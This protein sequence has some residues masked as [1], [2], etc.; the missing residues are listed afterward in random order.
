MATELPVL[1]PVQLKRIEAVHRGFLYQHLYAVGC[2][3]L[4][5]GADASSVIVE[6]DEDIEIV[7]PDRRLYV[8]VKTRTGPLTEGDIEGAMKRFAL[9]RRE[10]ANGKRP[11]VAAFAIVANAQPG[12]KLADRLKGED[13]P[14]DT[15]LCWPA[16]APTDKALPAAW[17]DVAE[18]LAS[19]ADLAA[20]LPFGSL[21]PETLVWKL[22]GLVM[23]AASGTPPHADHAFRAEEL[24]DLFEQLAVQLQDFP[25]PP[26]RYRSQAE[27]PDLTSDA[28]V[29]VITGFSGAGKTMWV[30][31]AAQHSTAALAYSDV[32]DTPGPAIALPL[33]RELAGRFFGKGGGLGQLLLPGATGTEMLRAI[34]LRLQ[35]EKVDATIVIDNAHRV[36]AENLRALVQQ[37]P[38]AHFIFLAQPGAAVQELQATLALTPEPLGGWTTDTIAAEAA[39]QGCRADYAACERLRNLTA[40][41][42]LYVQNVVQFTAAE[43]A[44][45]LMRFCDE[46][47]ARTHDVATVQE[48]ILRRVFEGLG[49]QS[50][51]TVAILCLA[52][53][54][55]ERAEAAALLAQI[56]GLDNRAF[57]RAIRELR[58]AGVIELFGGDR[59]KI[60][61]AMRVLGRAHLD[62]LGPDFEHAAQSALKDVL[63]ASILRE[64]D[65]AKFS[66]YFRVL[67]DLGDIKMLV[68]LVTDEFI[69]RWA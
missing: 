9:L 59:L 18:G 63:L 6:A 68:E 5:S 49:P 32:G 11:G 50:R 55:L 19:C 33:A 29:R 34:G 24:P 30:A 22:A 64:K 36:P 25:A 15:T 61:D 8:Q 21:V 38:H 48:I 67:A 17:R 43:Y 37:T 45:E 44:G 3:L 62:S 28:R 41:L 31:Q 66:L 27:E 52:D 58:S 65:L 47:E 20:A 23:Y 14:T 35:A 16:N 42:P 26:L 10:H 51:D 2:L 53:I 39:D 46:L 57:A 7:L 13:W 12:P 40:G 4:G 54:P 1:D 69:T 56:N 60:H